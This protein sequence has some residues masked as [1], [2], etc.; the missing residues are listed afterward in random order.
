[1]QEI[2]SNTSTSNTTTIINSP[3][4]TFSENEKV[5]AKFKNNLYE[6]KILKM[7]MRGSKTDSKKKQYF[8]IHYNGWNEKWDEWVDASKIFKINE[9]NRE[10]QSKLSTN[11]RG[12]KGPVGKLV[13]DGTL[14]D[15]EDDV[16]NENGGSGNLKKR[17]H[18]VL[19]ENTTVNT[20]EF[21]LPLNLKSVLVENWS[22]IVN[23]KMLVKLP[24]SPTISEIFKGYITS[25]QKDKDIDEVTEGLKSYFNKA[26]GPILL[27]KF[28]RLQYKDILKTYPK[29]PMSDIYGG[30][31]LLRLFVKLPLLLSTLNMEDK[32]IS[33]IK[34][35][36]EDILK[37]IEE[38]EITIFIKDYITP[39][40][41][42]VKSFTD[43]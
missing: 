27:Y 29:T 26:L 1:M 37:Y 3:S 31:H 13:E 20:V 7:E 40:N 16:E 23:D 19:S 6:A 35:S 43:K 24:K 4:E 15:S 32:T 25:R 38:N 33:I 8:F 18:E 14:S 12:R 9:T 17:K 2:S 21:T 39:S 41:A 11:S 22:L 10:L 5:L 30:E 42:Y 34:K 36:F 28:E